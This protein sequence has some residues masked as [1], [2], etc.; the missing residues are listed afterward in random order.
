[1][2][3]K[4]KSLDLLCLIFAGFL[5][6]T[7]PAKGLTVLTF[8]GLGLSEGAPVPTIDGVSFSAD[9]ARQGNPLFAFGTSSGSDLGV[10]GPFNA[11]GNTFITNP[12]GLNALN[13][14]KIVEL[15]FST[16]VTDLSLLVADI[17]SN[18]IITERVIAEA[19]GP[20]GGLLQSIS[21]NAPTT[22]N[23][24]D[25]VPVLIDF[26]SLGNISSLRVR[27]DPIFNPT[28]NT[29]NGWGIDNVSFNPVPEPGSLLLLGCGCILAVSR[30]SRVWMRVML[31]RD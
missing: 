24:G 5:L 1:M 30:R 15:T 12:G 11:V 3:S 6:Q 29:F 21:H 20:S 31:Q 14:V 2:T 13:T 17:D 26:G 28:N 7:L 25:G 18:S 16:P 22:G 23:N 10:G 27:N 8:E 19:F 9:V 4:L